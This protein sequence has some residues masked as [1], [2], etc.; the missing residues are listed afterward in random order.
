[1]SIYITVDNIYSNCYIYQMHGL[2][3]DLRY[4]ARSL[5]RS[6]TFSTTA[7]LVLGLGIGANTAVFTLVSRVLLEPLPF[8]EPERLVWIWSTR[9]DRARAFFSIPNL[10]DV[11]EES[12]SLESVAA[13]T[14]W[15]ASLT[16]HGE[17]ERLA[18]VRITGNAFPLL[19]VGTVVGRAL[20]SDD[21][22]P[23]RP[24]VAVLTNGCWQRLFGADASVVGRSLILSGD[25][26]TV[27]GVLAPEFRLPGEAEVELLV[28]LSP[29][30]DARRAERGTNF[31]RVFAR[32]APGASPALAAAELAS[33]TARL[34]ERYPDEN[35]KHTP[36]R[37]VDLR[38]EMVGAW[39]R[40]LLLLLGAV[41]LVLLVASTNLA[42]LFLGRATSRR[43][44]MAIRLAQGATRSRLFRLL[45]AEGA[46]LGALG[47]GL[48]VL[49]GLQLA[50]V[51]AAFAP[52]D[53]PRLSERGLDGRLLAF[54]SGLTLLSVLVFALAPARQASRV[55]PDRALREG[56]RGGEGGR[57]LR[58]LLVVSEVALSLVLLIGAGLLVESARRLLATS[59]G[60]DPGRLLIVRLSLPAA[61]YA[62]PEAVT[63]FCREV[64]GRVAALPGVRSV[65]MAS[66]LPLS[67]LNVRTDFEIVG[68]PARTV[69]EVPAAQNRWVGP[70]YF[71][72]LGIP[73]R[74]GRVFDP[75]DEAGGAPVVVVD[76]ALARRYFP[77]GDAVGSRLRLEDPRRGHY[78][79][80][81]VGVVGDVKHVGL[82][83]EPTPTLYAPMAQ[84]PETAVSFL[85]GRL[86]LVVRTKSEP[87][88]RAAAVRRSVQ[89]VDADVPA[90][91]VRSMDQ[92]LA[93]SVAPRRFQGLLLSLFSLAA[94]LLAAVG[95]YG[96]VAYAVA[97]RTREIGLRMALGAR[98]PDVVGLLVRQGG[99]RIGLGLAAGL[100]LSLG[101]TRLLAGVLF[102]IR[103]H[104]PATFALM[105][106][107]L[108]GV[109]LLAS[110]LPA[111]RAAG[112]DP[113][114]ALRSD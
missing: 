81:V 12:R 88:A 45:L 6:P 72:A 51:L 50:G 76:E 52:A 41:G 35:A 5:R 70:A 28:P 13:F 100:L 47:G 46:L 43:R 34:R 7:L 85:I 30:T 33:I 90:S 56:D 37:V 10:L 60:F 29:T 32:L 4:A 73:V 54:A 69:A 16:G 3:Q 96:L 80:E 102:G 110:A 87:L 84:V 23:G 106:S 19:G 95:L 107:L 62:R 48:G 82:D 24:R 14:A 58:D 94:L 111:R 15:A 109:G 17:P 67:G 49:L 61:R 104:D 57:R 40:P 65:G 93:A 18:G 97:C 92:W 114:V 77:E 113:A 86:H 8:R 31:L 44:E 21:D 26:Y 79:A 11:V 9:T 66:V 59:P 105:T 55:A 99:R 39:R 36:P 2:G 20:A 103:P 38:E 1:M 112:I 108:A 71:Q 78:D 22:Q 74:A 98:G 63:R 101:L 64:E 25:A 27:V 68:R 42:H 91:S 89:A 53:L 75:H 83:D